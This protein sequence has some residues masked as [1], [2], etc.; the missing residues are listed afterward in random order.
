MGVGVAGGAQAP[1][2]LSNTLAP[3]ATPSI[4]A[5]LVSLPSS[6]SMPCMLLRRALLWGFCQ[7]TPR[8]L[9]HLICTP[10][11]DSL[12]PPFS[13]SPLVKTTH[14]KQA[15]LAAAPPTRTLRTNTRARRRVSVCL[16][17]SQCVSSAC[18]IKRKGI[19]I[20]WRV[21][22]YTIRYRER[23]CTIL[24]SVEGKSLLA[25]RTRHVLLAEHHP[26]HTPPRLCRRLVFVLVLRRV[27]RGV[28]RFRPASR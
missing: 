3:R 17:V 26:P 23:K 16:S 14:A 24:D 11:F 21:P 20:D 6:A 19:A 18:T 9:A 15:T 12:H 4:N 10:A 27:G 7:S 13:P 2:P 22:V 25:S 5:H 1:T 28:V 8:A